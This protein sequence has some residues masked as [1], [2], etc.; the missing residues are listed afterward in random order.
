MK[1]IQATRGSLQPFLHFFSNFVDH[2]CSPN[3]IQPTK[4]YADPDL[5]Q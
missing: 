1:D 5:Q 4:I 2:F 3:R